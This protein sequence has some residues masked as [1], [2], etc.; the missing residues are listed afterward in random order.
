[1]PRKRNAMWRACLEL[2]AMTEE[3]EAKRGEILGAKLEGQMHKRSKQ[4]T[5]DIGAKPRRSGRRR[6]Q[7][8]RA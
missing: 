5:K 6:R 2:Q 1:M 7:S 4:L 8:S 3:L